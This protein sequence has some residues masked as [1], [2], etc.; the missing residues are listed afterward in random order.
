MLA[1]SFI[2]HPA[3]LSDKIFYYGVRLGLRPLYL[4]QLIGPSVYLVDTCIDVPALL[5]GCLRLSTRQADILPDIPAAFNVVVELLSTTIYVC[6]S[7]GSR[8]DVTHL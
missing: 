6:Q 3:D 1:V 2:P 4:R 8:R 7:H 5:H